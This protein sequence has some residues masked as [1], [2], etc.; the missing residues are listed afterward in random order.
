VFFVAVRN[1]T[2]PPSPDRR[3]VR[4]PATISRPLGQL[5]NKCF[6]EAP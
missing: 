5:T 1:P 6:N 2:R 3:G 4:F